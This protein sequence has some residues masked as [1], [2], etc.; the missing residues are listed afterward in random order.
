MSKKTIYAT[1]FLMAL[2]GTLP[3]FAQGKHGHWGEEQAIRIDIG[4]FEPDGDSRYWDDK[5]LDFTGSPDDFEDT[6]F[7]VSY[8]RFLSDRL[9]LEFSV[10]GADGD[11]DQAY[12]EFVDELGGDIFHSTSVEMTAL[13]LG[14]VVN[15]LPRDAPIVPYVG[16][17]GGLYAY[18]LVEAGDF[19]DF[20]AA[21]PF[22]FN[23]PV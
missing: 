8:I 2:G 1:V 17:G 20:D 13:T 7:S 9:G 14:L 5:A 21:P 16:I 10:T 4:V 12:L 22:I 11:A 19:I 15:L 23:D 3:A 6:S 18:E